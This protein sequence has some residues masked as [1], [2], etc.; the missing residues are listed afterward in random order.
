MVSRGGC[1]YHPLTRG[2]PPP[3]VSKYLL[4]DFLTGV[5]TD[6]L[7]DRIFYIPVLYNS[8]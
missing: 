1:D 5:M 2:R 6:V 3:K 8:V 4:T 7:T